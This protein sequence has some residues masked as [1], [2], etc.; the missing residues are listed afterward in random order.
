MR[1]NPKT[2]GPHRALVNISMV[3]K[4]ID[5]GAEVKIEMGPDAHMSQPRWSANGKHF[6]F[7]NTTADAIE[8]WIGDTATGKVHRI[9]GVRINGVM[10]PA[11]PFRQ[12]NPVFQ[13]MPDNRMLLVQTVP[14]N[15]GA[16]P[17]EPAIPAGP[18]IQESLGR[19]G[20]IRTYEDMLQNSHDEDL[21]DYYATAQL[22]WVDSMTAHVTPFGKP[23]IYE[24]AEIGRAHV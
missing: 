9:E 15:R 4:R 12:S 22:A 2:N 23:A 6:A 14:A 18:H 3:L 21:F 10:A 20:P 5:D 11:S 24:T 7:T 1:I 19:T 17:V 16:V 13:W 8:L